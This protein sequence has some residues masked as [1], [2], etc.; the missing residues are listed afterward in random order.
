MYF[1]NFEEIPRPW[2]EIVTIFM[3]ADGHDSICKLKCLLNTIS[4]MDVDVNVENASEIL[5]QFINGW[6]IYNAIYTKWWYVYF[7]MLLL[8]FNLRNVE[9]N[10]LSKCTT[11]DNIIDKAESTRLRLLRMMETT[12][13]VYTDFMIT[14]SQLSNKNNSFKVFLKYFFFMK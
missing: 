13:P 12:W 14:G 8:Y 7:T 1:T 3:K 10:M 11:Y 4:M 6:N 9:M 5:Q 2:K